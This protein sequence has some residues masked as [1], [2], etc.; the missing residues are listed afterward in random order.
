MKKI[1]LV[2]SILF[3]FSQLFSQGID[4]PRYQLEIHRGGVFLGNINIELFPLIAPLATNYFD[5]LVNVQA[6]DSTAFHR[7]VPGFV[8]QGGDPNS[9]HGPIS[10]W[11]NGNPNQPTVNAEFSVVQHKRG[12]IGAARDTDTN[13]ATSQFYICAGA[14][15]YLDG[16]YTVYGQVT[17]GLNWVD[18]IVSSPRNANDVPLLKIEMFVT[19]TGVNDS[20]PDAPQLLAP[21]DGSAG[22]ATTQA[23]QWSVSDQAVMYRLELSTDSTFATIDKTINSATASKTAAG[24]IGFTKYFWRVIAN[25]GGHE[26]GYSNVFSFTSATAGPQLIAPIDS[27][28]GLN[29][30]PIFTWDAVPGA[31]NYTL[32]IAK[33]ATFTPAVLVVNESAISA[34]SYQILPLLTN[35]KYYWRVQSFNGT[36]AGNYSQKFLFYTGTTL[37]LYSFTGNSKA[38]ELKAAYPNPTKDYITVDCVLKTPAVV[39]ITLQNTAGKTVYSTTVD[40]STNQ[41][42]KTI[43]VSAFHKGVYVI[44]VSCNGDVAKEKIEIL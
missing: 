5:S 26:S 23:F 22:V 6:Y 35:T 2:I 7:V 32:Q 19:A 14:P 4:K 17:S 10:T 30:N 29:L 16:Q 28:T 21:A 9:I 13:S 40:A 34:L 24:L 41:F 43:D 38:I 37:G 31:N 8:I 27:A 44:T 36:V 11:G 1:I 3:S 42:V 33:F 39:N 25:N 18:T 12:R 15:L 20:I